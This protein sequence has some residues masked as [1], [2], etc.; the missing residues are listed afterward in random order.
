LIWDAH[1]T[2]TH[3][4]LATSNSVTEYD[5]HGGPTGRR[6]LCPASPY[7]VAVDRNGATLYAEV[8]AGGKL[9]VWAVALQ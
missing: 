3:V 1:F 4:Y 5:L 2:P 6:W 7:L 9:A 8:F